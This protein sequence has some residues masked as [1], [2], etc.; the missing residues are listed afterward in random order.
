MGKIGGA[1]GGGAARSDIILSYIYIYKDIHSPV[2][3][4]VNSDSWGYS[5]TY[6]CI[7]I[8]LQQVY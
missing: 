2:L 3:N 7:R 1:N 5:S 8:V 6:A 4:S